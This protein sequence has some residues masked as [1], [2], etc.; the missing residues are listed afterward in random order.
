MFR[1]FCDEMDYNPAMV[2]TMLEDLG[3]TS[4]RIGKLNKAAARI[5]NDFEMYGECDP[6]DALM[7]C[8]LDQ[9]TDAEI[10]YLEGRL[11]S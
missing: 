5:R 9:L 3:H 1:T 2:F 7:S 8:D 6:E 10:E 11:N 4:T